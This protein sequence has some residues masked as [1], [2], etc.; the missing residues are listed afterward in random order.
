[1]KVRETLRGLARCDLCLVLAAAL[2]GLFFVGQVSAGASNQTVDDDE[3]P[4]AVVFAR[5][6]YKG[7]MRSTDEWDVRSN[8]D[9]ALL[10]YVA[11]ATNIKLSK[12]TWKERSVAVNDFEKMHTTPILYMT[13]QVDFEFTDAEVEAINE[14]FKRGGFL[15]ADDSDANDTRAFFF[16]PAVLRELKKFP[17]IEVKPLPKSHEI[18]HCFFDLPDG[19]PWDTRAAHHVSRHVRYPDMGLFFHDRMVG[20]LTATDQTYSWAGRRPIQGESLK[21]GTNVIVYALT[22]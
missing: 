14:Y 9:E 20:L 19:A 13:G 11:K 18:Y 10:R 15:F 22:H 17:D 5:F 8:G 7:Q 12:K 6:K 1:M 4:N 2:L 21:M 16:Y 3:D